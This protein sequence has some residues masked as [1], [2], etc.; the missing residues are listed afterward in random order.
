MALI[1]FR[2]D[3][4]LL[5]CSLLSSVHDSRHRRGL[6]KCT[7]RVRT[8]HKQRQ[9]TIHRS[10]HS[11]QRSIEKATNEKVRNQLKMPQVLALIPA[12]NVRDKF[13]E[14]K[15]ALDH[16]SN[17]AVL[18]W[19]A[20]FEKWYI[21][22]EVT[23]TTGRGRFKKTVTEWK[24]PPF[25]IAMLSVHDRILMDLPRTNNAVEAWHNSL[26][27]M[28][29]KHPKC[30]FFIDELRQEQLTTKHRGFFSKVCLILKLN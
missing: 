30:Y 26:Q 13:A 5:A 15:A 22:A 21:G 23:T 12:A 11:D 16:D 8:S 6:Q 7:S 29:Q 14:L 18:G 17:A 28:M 19:Y 9:G 4:R 27:T 10:A 25:Q 3:V 2:W 24:D 20:Y 1:G